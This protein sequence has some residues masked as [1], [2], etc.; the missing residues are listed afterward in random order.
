MT[1]SHLIASHFRLIWFHHMALH[2]Q[3]FISNYVN[4]FIPKILSRC[5]F[6]IAETSHMIATDRFDWLIWKY[7]QDSSDKDGRLATTKSLFA[8]LRWLQRSTARTVVA[9]TIQESLMD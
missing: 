3:C 9:R 2:H 5:D 6:D 4:L 1:A 7:G 8:I